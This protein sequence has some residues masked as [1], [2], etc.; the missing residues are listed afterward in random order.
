M[1]ADRLAFLDD[2][3]TDLTTV[4]ATHHS[5]PV[6]SGKVVR[7]I[8]LIGATLAASFSFVTLAAGVASASTSDNTAL[9]VPFCGVPNPVSYNHTK[10]CG[11]GFYYHDFI[12]SY[13]S[14][15]SGNKT[16]YVFWTHFSDLGCASDPGHETQVCT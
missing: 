9:A 4:P 10:S 6:K 13:A 14:G 1:D 11:V 15:P 5:A 3:E 12:Y 7:R 16:C 2:V 8:G